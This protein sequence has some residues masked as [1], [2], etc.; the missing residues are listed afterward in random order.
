MSATS[1]TYMESIIL[2]AYGKP[3]LLEVGKRP[4][5]EPATGQVLIKVMASPINPSDLIFLSGH[6][7]NARKLPSVPG[8][9]GSGTVVKS[10]G[11]KEADALIDKKVAFRSRPD[12]DGAWA[13]FTV[14]DADRCI[15][16]LDA[17][18]FTAGAMLLVNPLTAWT[19]VDCA[20]TGGHKC[21]IQNAAASALGRMVIKY[22]QERGLP[23]INI[24]RKSEHVDLLKSL[25]VEEI[26]N[27]ED[28]DFESQLACRAAALKATVAF[29]AVAGS[30]A[31]LL[32]KSMPRRSELW[33]YGGLS[34]QPVQ[35]DP[36]VLIYEQK[37]VRG[38]WGPPTFQQLPKDRFEAAAREIQEHLDTT[39]KTNV[40]KTFPL[41]DVQKALS[42]YQSNMSQGKILL[43]MN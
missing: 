30:A 13:Q 8:F 43:T 35:I 27:S 36:M 22:A 40:H 32:L 28:Q 33:S 1:T 15:P 31:N 5:G 38:F 23:L 7:P 17:V 25:G 24:V 21:A 2:T 14:T 39:F 6:N 20:L 37:V 3:P 12:I 34:E 19:L 41:G 29:D 26:L 9:E 16:L 4:V 18:S 42:E 10:G 11:G